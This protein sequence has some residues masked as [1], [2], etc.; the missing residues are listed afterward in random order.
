M[1]NMDPKAMESL[2]YE[3]MNPKVMESLFY[4]Q[5]ES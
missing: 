1:N 3:N 5:Y 4:K 2:F